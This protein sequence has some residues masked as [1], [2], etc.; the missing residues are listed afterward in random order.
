MVCCL[1]C[2]SVFV[3]SGCLYQR[4]CER[5]RFELSC[6]WDVAPYKY[7]NYYYYMTCEL[8]STVVLTG[9]G[10][11]SDWV[12]LTQD[13][14]MSRAPH[15]VALGGIFTSTTYWL[16]QR[17]LCSWR[18]HKVRHSYT[19]GTLILNQEW[20]KVTESKTHY[21]PPSGVCCS[22]PAGWGELSFRWGNKNFR[23]AVTSWNLDKIDNW[24]DIFPIVTESR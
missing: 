7:C 13:C 2:P 18:V 8:W 23:T 20:R 19:Q 22:P 21:E 17:W 12:S 3:T 4:L 1:V 5:E 6:K 9:T 11:S 14:C 24:Q 10:R 16:T 15:S